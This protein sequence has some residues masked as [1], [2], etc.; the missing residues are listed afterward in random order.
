MVDQDD[1]HLRLLVIFHYITA[2]LSVLGLAFLAL[3]FFIMRTFMMNEKIWENAK[4]SGPPPAEFFVMFQWFYLFAAFMMIVALVV[5]LVAARFMQ[6]R[7]N[8]M[9]CMV[10]AGLNCIQIPLGTVLG[11]FTIIVL[12]RDSVKQKFARF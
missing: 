12:N 9:F 5:E 1:Q 8:W 3:H 11:V 4:N 10:V 6:Q 2:G 7:K